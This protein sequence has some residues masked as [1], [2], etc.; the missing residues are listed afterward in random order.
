[1]TRRDA[2]DDA[3][4]AEHRAFARQANRETWDLIQQPV[5][6]A[7][8]DERMIHSAHASAFHWAAVGGAVES[9]RADWLLSHV[10]A[11]LGR[12]EPALR[13]AQQCLATCV[14]EGIGD[15]DLAYAREAVARAVAVGGDVGSA[16]RLRA[17][18][19]RAGDD[20]AD[21]KDRDQF[22]ADLAAE[23]WYGVRP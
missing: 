3:E 17:E 4:Q 14:R 20:I 5:R 18:A 11:V 1:M 6:S 2:E 21:A 22:L 12:A 19:A 7:V 9:T 15:F 10:H 16:A 13:Y 23:P 8:D